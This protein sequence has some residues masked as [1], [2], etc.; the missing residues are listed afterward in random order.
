MWS[1]CSCKNYKKINKNV[2]YKE[3]KRSTFLDPKKKREAHSL[4]RQKGRRKADVIG[5]IGEEEIKK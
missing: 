4:K 3:K 2:L 1:I 5:R